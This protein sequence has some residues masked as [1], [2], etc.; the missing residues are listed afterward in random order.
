MPPSINHE[1]RNRVIEQWLSGIPRDKIALDNKIGTGTVSSIVR[2]WEKGLV[3][4][5]IKS[6]RQLTVQI[7]KQGMNLSECAN[8]ARLVNRIK[9]SGGNTRD[10]EKLLTRIHSRCISIG[11]PSEK[12][13]QLLMQLFNISK[14]ESIPLE[15]VPEYITQKIHNLKQELEAKRSR[16]H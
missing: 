9:R 7:R 11:L 1:I 10:I 16:L 4:N 14:S 15:S 3:D 12:I 5:D 2:D 6:I 13:S 8:I